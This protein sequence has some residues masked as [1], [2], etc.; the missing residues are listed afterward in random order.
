MIIDMWYGNDTKDATRIDCWFNDLDCSYR[1]NIWIDSEIVGDYYTEDST[2]IERTFPFFSFRRLLLLQTGICCLK[3]K[4]RRYKD[5]KDNGGMK[6][7]ELLHSESR[8]K[9]DRSLFR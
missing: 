6:N 4:S 9:R 1:G 8:V 7:D 5:I 3:S 2:E